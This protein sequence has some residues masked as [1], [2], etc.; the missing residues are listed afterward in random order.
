[1]LHKNTN[2]IGQFVIFYICDYTRENKSQHVY[3][4]DLY[5]I[6]EEK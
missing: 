5:R 1:M 3:N 2:L 6:M 4:K